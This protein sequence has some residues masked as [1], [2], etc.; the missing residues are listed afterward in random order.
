ML[1]ATAVLG[2]PAAAQDSVRR[3]DGLA[4]PASPAPADNALIDAMVKEFGLIQS[5]SSDNNLRVPLTPRDWTLSGLRPY[6]A[7]SA[8]TLKPVTDSL[9]GLATPSRESTE[10]LSHGLGLGA[11][12]E[13]Q[14]SERFGFFGEYLFQAR[15]GTGVPSSS[16]T[17]RPDAEAPAGLKGGF[18]VRF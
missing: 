6:A 3:T 9:V 7:L 13:W 11:G 12:V 16:P 5:R 2:G 4:I 15:P 10:D 17:L 14:L 18:S 1:G 8:R